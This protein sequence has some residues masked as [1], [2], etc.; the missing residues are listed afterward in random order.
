MT[1]LHSCGTLAR[2]AR[3]I[4]P[5]GNWSFS[6]R[7]F[8]LQTFVVIGDGSYAYRMLITSDLEVRV[9]DA[10]GDLIIPIDSLG[11]YLAR[12]TRELVVAFH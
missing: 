7:I 11:D 9:S 12:R 2:L 4:A 6:W 5:H 8:W 3:Q 1:S 10:L